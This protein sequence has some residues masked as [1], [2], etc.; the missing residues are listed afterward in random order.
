ME[1]DWENMPSLGDVHA[2]ETINSET[3][4]AEFEN[5][6]MSCDA[7]AGRA[8][9]R[10]Y[11]F[12]IQNLPCSGSLTDAVVGLSSQPAGHGAA[13]ALLLRAMSAQGVV[14]SK[15]PNLTRAVV[16]VV[17]GALPEVPTLADVS[18]KLQNFEKFALFEQIHGQ[19]LE[20]LE[21][22]R[23]D[24]SSVDSIIASKAAI[25]KCL[26]HPLTKQYCLPY[27]V[28][29]VADRVDTLLG[30]VARVHRVEATLGDDVDA[31]R[32]EI[33][34]DR[35]LASA[36][37]SFL[38]TQHLLPFLDHVD[39]AVE[40]LLKSVRARFQSTIER[41]AP[42]IELQK[43]YPLHEAGREL[44]VTVPMRNTG[45]G[46]GINVGFRI[47][48]ESEYVLIDE[49]E[50]SLGNVPL[51]EFALTFKAIVV[52]PCSDF[53]A[54][55][56]VS[57]GE[58]GNPR[59]AEDIFDIKVLAQRSDVDWNRYK[60]LNPYAEAPASGGRFV[61]R[62]EQV[63]TLVSR[64]LQTPME[65]A[66]IDGQ[67]RVG[68]TS[69]AQTAA[70]QAVRHHPDGKL[71]KL[72]ILWGNI[73][74]EEA[75]T[76]LR[77][78]GKEI[79]DFIIAALPV[80]TWERGNYEGS[81]APLLKLAQQ[82]HGI[83]PDRRFVI[84]I[85]EFDD[86]DQELYLQ[87][88]LAETFF[89]NIRAITA[90][91]NICLLLVGSENMP[92]IMDR[93][94]QKL[95]RFSR[96]NLTYFSRLADWEDFQQLV[97]RPSDG[98]LDWHLDAISE[99]F[100]LSSGNPYFAKIICRAVMARAVRERDTDVTAID[101]RSVAP[102]TIDRL[103]SNQFAHMWQD[104]IYSPIEEREAVSLK[105]R[106]TLAALARC[107]R[108][109]E[110]ASLENI[111]GQRGALQI[112]EGELSSLLG[113]FVTRDVL[114]ESLGTYDFKLPMFRAWLMGVGLSRLA[115]DRLSEEL[116]GIDE[117]LQEE[118]RV[119]AEE[120]VA[121]ADSWPPYR[122]KEIG[123]ER[124]RAWLSQ[125]SSQRDQR[126]LFTLLKSLRVVSTEE[127]L[128]RLRLAGH[129][130]RDAIG[131]SIGK[132]A[133]ERTRD[134]IVITYVDGEGK[135][136]QRYASD[137]AEENKISRKA[138]LPPSSF[139][140]ALREYI[141]T[142]R[143]GT[144][145]KAVVIV[146]DVVATGKSLARNVGRFIQQHSTLLA[147]TKPK[148]MIYALF[149]TEQGTDRVRTAISTMQYD[150]VD[151]RAGEILDEDVFAF[152]GETGVFG[153]KAD[154]DRAKAMA[155]DI[156][157]HIYPD[158]PLGY[159]NQGLLLVMPN[160]VPNNTL[161]ILHSSSKTTANWT[162]LFERLVN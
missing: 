68:K 130:I 24:Y 162:P 44:R 121:L 137:L 138:I 156:G 9:L 64:M 2:D 139:D 110:P 135:S 36:K 42:G 119:T 107:L 152:A 59:P 4:V 127:N 31:C 97:R 60:Y 111:Y 51:G 150:D 124:I 30:V 153:I 103:E 34:A 12:T 77:S 45:P 117:Q 20:R 69:L 82:A 83:D 56:H 112:S 144:P 13:A 141:R 81:L 55:I 43:R 120:I 123:P 122:G 72:Y 63:A 54:D 154:R 114:V 133:S 104:G 160:T 78:L 76:T 14:N 73:A 40:R 15:V 113:N 145:P 100:T 98:V 143:K 29:E 108:S 88:S 86:I 5:A 47:S 87:G 22:L 161:P 96:V 46:D 6:L 95:N 109:G 89:A 92:Y 41:S 146:D 26:R 35:A 106:R 39:A 50:I 66:Y 101:V 125:R 16:E 157:A 52:E 33:A 8:A 159:D 74:A 23:T 136:G 116:A 118:A 85:D 67:K 142:V 149:A 128:R 10:H 65:P 49:A 94:G 102:A 21:P 48:S 70:D 61:G 147:E 7:E 84:V 38:T 75:R 62:Q 27:G 79:E 91:P 148:V 99:V 53:S 11:L 126:L 37:P 1:R 129:V 115:N 90:T 71:H 3:L 151:F 25:M 18:P 132:S 134:D 19:V 17:E 158:S 58:I 140:K 32:K 93:Q 28:S 131:P 57:W 105:R 80:G 155:E